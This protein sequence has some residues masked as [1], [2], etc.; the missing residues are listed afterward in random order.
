MYV[1]SVM[2]VAS[3]KIRASFSKLKMQP[4]AEAEAE[5]EARLICNLHL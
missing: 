2:C 1:V 4:N 3:L 5:A